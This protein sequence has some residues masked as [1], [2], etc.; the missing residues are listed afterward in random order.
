MRLVFSSLGEKLLLGIC[1]SQLVPLCM[2][3]YFAET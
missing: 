2:A 1:F 3:K